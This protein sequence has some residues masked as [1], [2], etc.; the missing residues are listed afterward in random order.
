MASG[1]AAITKDITPKAMK[2]CCWWRG[3]PLGER[4]E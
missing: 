1:E 3:T 2:T 4:W